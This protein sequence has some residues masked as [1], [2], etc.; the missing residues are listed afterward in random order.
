M[1]SSI[2]LDTDPWIKFS[3]VTLWFCGAIYVLIG[4]VGVIFGALPAL[5]S[6]RGGAAFG[7][8]F[9]GM[10]LLVGVGCGIG[11]FV[12][13]VGLAR[14]RKWAWIV[15]VIIGGIYAPSGC[16]PFGAIL[17]YAMLRKGV[18]EELEAAAG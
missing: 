4:L 3:V 10:F 9:G 7:V 16:L 15:T 2:D 6:A 13:A 1:N 12:A 14:R 8:L 11:N 5:S 18:R 17:L